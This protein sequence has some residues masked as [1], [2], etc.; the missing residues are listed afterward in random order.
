VTLGYNLRRYVPVLGMGSSHARHD[1]ILTDW[2]TQDGRDITV[3]R[4][5]APDQDEYAAWFQNVEID[6]FEQRGARFWVVRGRA[7]DYAAYRDS[8]LAD[9]RR[10]YYGLPPWLPQTG[11][12]FCD[13]YFQG[14]TCTR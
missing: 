5:S 2:R 12:Y 1:D 13:R 4:K 7:F 9:V 3:L 14:A 6:S 10:R 8:V 11:C